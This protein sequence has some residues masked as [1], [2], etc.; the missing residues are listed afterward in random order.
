M[1]GEGVGVS[2]PAVQPLLWEVLVVLDWGE[3]E[4]RDEVVGTGLVGCFLNLW[5][6]RSHKTYGPWHQAWSMKKAEGEW[7]VG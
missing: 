7:L 6:E 3:R 5:T 1:A 2:A 4:E